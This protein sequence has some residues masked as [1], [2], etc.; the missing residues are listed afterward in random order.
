MNKINENVPIINEYKI[1]KVITDIYLTSNITIQVNNYL[2]SHL[3]KYKNVDYSCILFKYNYSINYYGLIQPDIACISISNIKSKFFKISENLLILIDLNLE[4]CLFDYKQNTV[5]NNL[6]LIYKLNLNEI[7]YLNREDLNKTEYIININCSELNKEYVLITLVTNHSNLFYIKL[8]VY[9]YNVILLNEFNIINKAIDLIKSYNLFD[10]DNLISKIK[11]HNSNLLLF[12]LNCNSI[13][14]INLNDSNSVELI[15]SKADLKIDNYEII[16]YSAYDY[17]KDYYILCAFIQNSLYIVLIHKSKNSNNKNDYNLLKSIVVCNYDYETSDKFYMQNS[18]LSDDNKLYFII[19]KNEIR[20]LDIITIVNNYIN[21]NSIKPKNYTIKLSYNKRKN[22]NSLLNLSKILFA[23]NE[24]LIATNNEEDDIYV[25]EKE[26]DKYKIIY[27]D[28]LFSNNNY[29]VLINDINCKYY[30]FLNI[31]FTND[32]NIKYKAKT[33]QKNLLTNNIINN[34]DNLKNKKLTKK[35][36]LFFENDIEYL[37]TNKETKYAKINNSYN[38]LKNCIYKYQ[39]LFIQLN[40]LFKNIKNVDLNKEITMQNSFYDNYN[41]FGYFCNNSN[42]ANAFKFE[43]IFLLFFKY[44]FI[45]NK[46]KN[47][48]S[49][50]ECDLLLSNKTFLINSIYNNILYITIK[51]TDKNNFYYNSIKTNY[52]IIKIYRQNILKNRLKM[53]YNIAIKS[54]DYKSLLKLKQININSI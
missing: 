42:I 21:K 25:I 22:N 27:N 39:K 6:L 37:I 51:F 33:L 24:Y 34:F 31:W 16:N 11:V 41:K 52:N 3:K 48:N 9:T 18:K 43:K 54:C 29:Y 20:C 2:K 53:L 13:I 50:I 23:N 47:F 26:K 17:N 4:L 10:L 8:N 38:C 35:F 44:N 14:A 30:K 5:E 19:S 36:E 49:S 1:S 32:N 45:A 12:I 46:L 7:I 15:L 28:T 40:C